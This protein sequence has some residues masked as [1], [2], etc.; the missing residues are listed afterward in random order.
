MGTLFYMVV[1]RNE[2]T[3]VCFTVPLREHFSLPFFYAML[4]SVARFF[5]IHPEMP[6]KPMI[7][8][9]STKKFALV[10]IYVMTFIFVITWQFAQFALF[11][12]SVIC[13]ALATTQ[14]LNKDQ[15]SQIFC[16][17]LCAIL[18]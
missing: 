14:L 9:W 2:I 1:H 3:R 17:Q 8:L 15:V 6:N 5:S 10:Q 18:T 16:A 4:V 13:F 7:N 11:L 12:H